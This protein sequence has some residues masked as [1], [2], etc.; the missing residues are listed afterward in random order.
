MKRVLIIP[1]AAVSL[2]ASSAYAQEPANPCGSLKNGYGP[3]DYRTSKAE[4]D[5]V[6]QFHLTPDVELLR[7][8]NT[9]TIAGDLDYTLR[10]S[11]NHHRALMAMVNLS[12]KQKTDRPNGPRGYTV[13]CYFDRAFRFA[14]DDGKVK[15]IY[16]VW[17][18]RINKKPEAVRVLEAARETEDNN[19]NLHYNLGLVYFDLKD[20]PHALESAQRAYQLGAQFP[21]LRNKLKAA[22]AWKEPKPDTPSASAATPSASANVET[23]SA[24]PKAP[25][26]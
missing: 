21:G 3:Y 23:P 13:D 11:P 1:L 19:A 7:H 10:A 9:A 25:A 5:I 14:A 8:G 22:G 2:A 15:I 16:G 12:L 6:E 20:M 24:E 26:R 4:L 18:Y 17:L